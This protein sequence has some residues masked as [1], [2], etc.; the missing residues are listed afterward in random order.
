[1]EFGYFYLLAYHIQLFTTTFF[2]GC[3]WTNYF[4]LV[5]TWGEYFMPG[6]N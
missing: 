5:L 1:M 4:G 3:I 6:I 2:G